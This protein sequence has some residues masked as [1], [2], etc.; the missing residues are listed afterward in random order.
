VGWAGPSY[1][2][3]LLSSQAAGALAGIAWHCYGGAPTVMSDSHAQAPE[4]DQIVT[5]CS[6]GIEPYPVPEVLIGS[7]RNWA[8]AV[9]L[10]N[11]ALD[12]AGGPVQPPNSGCMSCTGE[13]TINES[14]QTVNFRLAYF[15]LGQ[16]SAFVRRGATRVGSNSFVSYY[17]ASPHHFRA[18]PGLDDVAFVNPDGT[19]VLVA[20]NNSTSP[21]RFGVAWTGRGFEYSLPAKATVTF[22]W[23]P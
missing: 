6:Q 11:L 23:K 22:S 7:L 13:V 1:P 3:A 5:E 21:T 4:R 10:W 8:S 19:R 14:T 17:E 9:T 16:V 20:Y 15:Q 18:S 12:P 2:S